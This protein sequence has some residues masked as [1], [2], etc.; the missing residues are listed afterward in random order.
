MYFLF[1]PL[2]EAGIWRWGGLGTPATWRRARSAREVGFKGFAGLDYRHRLGGC[3]GRSGVLLSCAHIVGG[4]GS[5]AGF[6]LGQETK[7]RGSCLREILRLGLQAA[8]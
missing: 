8:G 3:A 4:D 6:C 7:V 1:F 5:R 2:F